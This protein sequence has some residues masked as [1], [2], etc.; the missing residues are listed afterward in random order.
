MGRP[1]STYTITS[2]YIEIL[3]YSIVTNNCWMENNPDGKSTFSSSLFRAIVAPNHLAF[4]KILSNL[5]HFCLNFQIFLPLFDS[6][7][8]FV[9]VFF[10][11]MTCIPDFLEYVLGNL[12][13]VLVYLLLDFESKQVI[14]LWKVSKHNKKD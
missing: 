6:F 2:M 11:K 8:F 5:V 13:K 10:C 14:I 1:F 7:F 3:S 12:L 9:V 4:F